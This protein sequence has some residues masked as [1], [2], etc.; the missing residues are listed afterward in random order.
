MDL[1]WETGCRSQQPC[2][3]AHPQSS[4]GI[5]GTKE[6]VIFGGPRLIRSRVTSSYAPWALLMAPSTP[7][8]NFHSAGALVW[9]HHGAAF[10]GETISS[11]LAGILDRLTLRTRAEVQTA[12]V[13][14]VHPTLVKRFC[15]SACSCGVRTP[16]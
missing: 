5:P 4:P 13:D 10:A 3:Q 11:S 8:R 2:L 1:G 7:W 12:V 16:P 15:G 9:L 6:T 14:F